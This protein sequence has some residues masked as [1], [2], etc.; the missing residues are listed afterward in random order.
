MWIPISER[1]PTAQDADAWGCVLVWHVYNGTQMLGWDNP[2]LG[3][4]KL[5]THWMSPPDAPGISRK[6]AVEITRTYCKGSNN[7]D[8]I[9]C[10]ACQIA[11]AIDAVDGVG[12][13]PVRYGRWIKAKGKT[14]LWYCSECGEKILYNPKKRIYNV[15]KLPVF[16]KNKF[17]RSCGAKME[18]E[19]EPAERE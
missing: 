11:D 13:A 15:L 14:N 3:T 18:S 5:I 1:R 10:E 16:E 9:R 6:A 12:A 4:S 19:K 7:C 17:C 2:M 8:G